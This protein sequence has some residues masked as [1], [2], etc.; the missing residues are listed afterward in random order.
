MAGVGK[1]SVILLD[2]TGESMV[3]GRGMSHIQQNV[4]NPLKELRFE[5]SGHRMFKSVYLMGAPRIIL[6]N[7]RTGKLLEGGRNSEEEYMQF[8]RFRLLAK[9]NVE[10]EPLD[11]TEQVDNR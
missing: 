1:D 5:A 4:I 6:R 9:V 2:F 11:E 8:V 10:D 3:V 7:A